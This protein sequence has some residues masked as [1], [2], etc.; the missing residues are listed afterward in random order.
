MTEAV[1][2]SDG[3]GQHPNSL[4]NLRPIQPGQVLNPSGRPRQVATRLLREMA[5][6]PIEGGSD[7]ETRLRRIVDQLLSK[8]EGGDLDAIKV[9]LD[10]M[11]GRPRQSLTV[12]SDSRERIDRAVDNLISTAAQNGDTLTREAA[13]ALLAEFDDEAAA[14]LNE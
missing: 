9:V 13:L 7:G 8:A 12:T 10:R 6:V 4:R 11:E 2:K 3:R 1:K 5:A 14:L